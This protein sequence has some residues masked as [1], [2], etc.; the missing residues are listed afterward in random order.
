MKRLRRGKQ[1]ASHFIKR[2]FMHLDSKAV[3]I[4]QI[5][6]VSP[7]FA[8]NAI[9]NSWRT[10]N[11]QCLLARQK[12]AQQ[13]IKTDEMIDMTVRNEHVSHAQQFGRRKRFVLAQIK[14]QRPPFPAQ[15]NIQ[16]WITEGTIDQASGKRRIHIVIRNGE[17]TLSSTQATGRN[18]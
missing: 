18:T 10:K 12:Q 9:N 3:V 2:D 8:G 13:A 14:E 1:H 6:G 16:A 7:Q 15:M 17:N 4:D 5:P 11:M